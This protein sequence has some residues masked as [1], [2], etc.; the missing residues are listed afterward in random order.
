MKKILII[1]K[2]S[3]IGKQLYT[4]AMKQMKDEIV[5]DMV[6]ATNNEWQQIK[7][8]HYDTV[9]LLSAIVHKKE[10]KSLKELYYKVNYLMAV[11]IAKKAK[12]DGV[13]QF[14]FMSTAA[15]FG[16]EVTSITKDTVPN[17]NTYYGKSK[18]YAECEIMTLHSESF[19]VSIVRPPMVYGEG[20]KGNYEKLIKLAR[21]LFAFPEFYNKRSMIDIN[22]LIQFIIYIIQG[23]CHGYYHPQ[24]ETYV[25]TCDLVIKIRERMGKKTILLS[26]NKK[27]LIVLAK[28]N[29]TFN[30]LFGDF[31]YDM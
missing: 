12:D 30:K 9:I 11:E 8:S 26:F 20:C 1:G 17:P 23:E 2:N 7:F 13:S 28:Y 6:S 14:I 25:S 10:R 19:K 3:Y 5:V 31:Y 24:D 21:Y 16:N 27:A 4:F 18:L 15:V 22:K 29:N